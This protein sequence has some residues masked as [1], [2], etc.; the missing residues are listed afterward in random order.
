MKAPAFRKRNAKRCSKDFTD[1]T[2]R[3]EDSAWASR[4]S[5]GSSRATAERSG[6]S[7][8]KKVPG[9]YS[10]CRYRKMSEKKKILV[11]D[12]DSQILRVLRHILNARDYTVRTAEDGA[13]ALEVF[14]ETKPDLVLTDL[15]MP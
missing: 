5:A 7:P 9:S 3:A 13:A 15:Q 6:S 12:D 4:S 2:G 14:E 10:T 8:A 1:P 11:V